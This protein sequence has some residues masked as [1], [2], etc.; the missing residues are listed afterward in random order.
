[1]FEVKMYTIKDLTKILNVS[2]RT[3]HTYIKEGRLKGA[4]KLGGK[5]QISEDN[6]KR[7][8]QGE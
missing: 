8:L 2:P 3:L 7:F 4:I 1:M 6:I 5:W